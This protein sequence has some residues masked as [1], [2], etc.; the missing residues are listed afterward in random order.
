MMTPAFQTAMTLLMV[1]KQEIE[2]DSLNCLHAPKTAAD[3]IPLPINSSSC[4][5]CP[6]MTRVQIRASS[7]HSILTLQVRHTVVIG[8]TALETVPRG[9]GVFLPSGSLALS[10][11]GTWNRT[12][13]DADVLH[14]SQAV[15]FLVQYL[16]RVWC[17]AVFFSNANPLKNAE[18][19]GITGVSE[20]L[21]AGNTQSSNGKNP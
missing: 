1:E 9:V 6:T 12:P 10:I 15:R 3:Y 5:H 19:L 8:E 17:S 18:Q 13:V 11:S 14:R 20:P 2:Q 21:K 7:G 16:R 4:V